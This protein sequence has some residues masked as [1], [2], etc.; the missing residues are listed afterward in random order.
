MVRRL[1][2]NTLMAERHGKRQLGYFT[3]FT[4]SVKNNPIPPTHLEMCRVKAAR[5]EKSRHHKLKLLIAFNFP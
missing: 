5:E 1:N 3:I 2:N 4:F